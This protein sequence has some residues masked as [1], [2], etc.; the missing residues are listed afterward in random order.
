MDR[1]ACWWGNWEKPATLTQG[2]NQ[3]LE[4]IFRDDGISGLHVLPPQHLHSVETRRKCSLLLEE[5][6]AGGE[7]S[8]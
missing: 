5:L 6:R 7:E 1:V 4:G 8:A 3:N 2:Q